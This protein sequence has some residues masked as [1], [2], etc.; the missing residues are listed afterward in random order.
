MTT[1]FNTDPFPQLHVEPRWVST[2]IEQA[3]AFTGTEPEALD[4]PH[5]VGCRIRSAFHEAGHCI[6]ALAH[7]VRVGLTTIVP[8]D[9]Y[10]G[11]TQFVFRDPATAAAIPVLAWAGVA[12]EFPY[13]DFAGWLAHHDLDAEDEDALL[14]RARRLPHG[15]AVERI[16]EG[17]STDRRI[18][19]AVDPGAFAAAQQTLLTHAAPVRH[20]AQL[21]LARGTLDEQTILYALGL[22]E[23]REDVARQTGNAA[24][25]ANGRAR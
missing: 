11:R 10:R 9:R 24:A 13:F 25:A 22:D 17:S 21:L 12:A 16:L 18:E 5:V 8:T 1:E 20:I 6:A 23:D 4:A 14:A 3:A 15:F 7:E 2:W 19:P